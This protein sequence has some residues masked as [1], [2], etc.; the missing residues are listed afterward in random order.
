MWVNSSVGELFQD[1]QWMIE[2]THM[3]GSVVFF[4]YITCD[5]I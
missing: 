5:K 3:I 4:L 1:P 2:A